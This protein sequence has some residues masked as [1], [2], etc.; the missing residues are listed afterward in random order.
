[1]PKVGME[2]VRRRQLIEATCVTV[3]RYGLAETT[4]QRIAHEA[5][6]S[7]GIV[8]HY[9][10]GKADLLAQTMRALLEDLRVDVV[11]RLRRADG[12]AARVAAVLDANFAP[13]QFQPAVVAT[14]LAF[15]AEAPHVPALH[16]L[17]R[18]YTRRTLANL[19]GPLRRLLGAAA[20]AE[21]ATLLAAVID[22]FWLRAAQEEPDFDRSAARLQI[23]RLVAALLAG[24]GC[25]PAPMPDEGNAVSRRG[26][27]WP[28][29]R[30]NS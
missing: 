16:R 1:M 30:G 29:P 25:N 2:A 5:G 28:S 3:H 22:G 19:R 10:A 15:W 24:A 13:S 23:D 8:H 14:W 11:V 6:L 17:R 9:F 27:P 21:A 12:D 20:G 18:I 4:V 7:T 26:P